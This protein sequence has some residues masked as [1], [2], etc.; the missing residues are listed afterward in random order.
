VILELID[1]AV[2]A[3]A[4]RFKACQILGL[5]VRSTERWRTQDGGEDGRAGP[6]T[7]PIHKLSEEERTAVLG[8]ANSLEFR[9]KSP[10]QIVPTLADRGEYIA[11]ES[12]F[13]RV[14]H[15][16]GLM[17]HRDR[18]KP[19]TSRKPDEH[20]ARG[21]NQVWCWDI[22]YLRSSMRGA[23]FYLYMVLDRHSGAHAVEG[24]RGLPTSSR[25]RRHP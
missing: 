9:G 2:A 17:Q 25:R 16:E 13:Y 19:R 1:E 8:V 5:S 22:T 23:F 15:E 3:G 10:R 11:S 6:R 7:P 4:R 18:A 20:V 14:L 21:P 12:T 24:S